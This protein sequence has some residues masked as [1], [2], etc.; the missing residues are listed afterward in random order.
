MA[1]AWPATP[2]RRPR[3]CPPQGGS[4]VR[5]S[6]V[7]HLLRG[8]VPHWAGRNHRP[9]STSTG[10][11][12]KALVRR[13]KRGRVQQRWNFFARTERVP[14]LTPSHLTGPG[15]LTMLGP[16][17]RGEGPHRALAMRT[18]PSDGAAGGCRNRQSVNDAARPELR[19]A[20]A[21]FKTTTT[22]EPTRMRPRT[23]SSAGLTAVDPASAVSRV[24][25]V[26]SDQSRGQAAR[27]ETTTTPR[28]GLK[29][30]THREVGS[31]DTPVFLGRI[32][33]KRRAS[34]F[35]E[36]RACSGGGCRLVGDWSSRRDL[37]R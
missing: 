32:T 33:P 20:L 26:Q 9:C 11:N 15:I 4:A 22:P 16:A 29:V 5:A 36:R 35:V 28:T 3:R 21:F 37:G 12:T 25:G 10:L 19:L 1:T 14:F 17:R 31:R 2:G 27:L 8:R 13:P 24:I 23:A 30:S 34:V 6:S 18:R 7:E